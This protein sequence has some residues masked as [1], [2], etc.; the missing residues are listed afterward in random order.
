MIRFSHAL[1]RIEVDAYAGLACDWVIR[2][3]VNDPCCETIPRSWL[4]AHFF[5][6]FDEYVHK[7]THMWCDISRKIGSHHRDVYG[8]AGPFRT[9]LAGGTNLSRNLKAYARTK[10]A[11]RL[12]Q[13]SSRLPTE[14]TTMLEWPLF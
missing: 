14:G 7:L 9:E 12:R 13:A 5:R 3:N 8:L 11:L 2:L 4:P 10:T 6:D 1:V